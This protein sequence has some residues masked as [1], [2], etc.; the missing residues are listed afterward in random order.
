MKRA[1][2]IADS[3]G[4]AY[5]IEAQSIKRHSNSMGWDADIDY[6]RNL[7]R[8]NST[9]DLSEYDAVFWLFWYHAISLGP[10]LQGF[11][12]RKS[13]VLV[14]SHVGWQKR[15]ISKSELNKIL[16]SFPGVGA[17]SQKLLEEIDIEGSIQIPHGVDRS[18]FRFRRMRKSSILTLMWVGNPEIG[19]HGD[20]KGFNSII[21]PVVS[22]LDST[23]VKLISATPENLVPYEMMP[24]FYSRG[25]IL[26]VTSESEGNPMPVIESMHT[27][28]PVIST[29]VGVVPELVRNGKNGWIIERNRSSLQN[30]IEEAMKSRTR[31]AMMGISAKKSVWNRTSKKKAKAVFKLL[32]RCVEG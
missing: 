9:T 28:R 7:R 27:G 16:S 11:D 14:S 13:A 5:D 32:D 15:G 31:L 22:E 21:R 17:S 8:K 25:D 19:H 20:L 12:F 18:R 10:R 1:L 2:L 6:V 24:D 3:P 23:K 4:W 30:A 26:L 29:D